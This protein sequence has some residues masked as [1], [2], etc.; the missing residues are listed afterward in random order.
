VSMGTTQSS[1]VIPAL[2]NITTTWRKYV[3]KTTK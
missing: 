3:S 2:Q 1:T